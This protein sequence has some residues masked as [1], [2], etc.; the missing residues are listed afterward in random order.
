M[1]LVMAASG[2]NAVTGLAWVQRLTDANRSWSAVASSADGVN[3]V[4]AFTSGYIYTSSDSG[5]TW[6]ERTSA[7]NRYWQCLACSANGSVIIAGSDG[8]F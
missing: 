2:N 1:A 3:L 8:N 7:G 6:T 4:A 5:A